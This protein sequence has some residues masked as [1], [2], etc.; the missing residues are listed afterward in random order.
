MDKDVHGL[1]GHRNCVSHPTN[2]GIVSI[3]MNVTKSKN[4]LNGKI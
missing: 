4:R 3:I 1:V 2:N